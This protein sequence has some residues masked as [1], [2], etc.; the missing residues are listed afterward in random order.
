MLRLAAQ[1]LQLATLGT[2][3]SAFALSR[4]LPTSLFN[5]ST[6]AGTEAEQKPTARLWVGNLPFKATQE[7]IQSFFNP[8]GA[9]SVFILR[10]K[11]T[12]KNR[13]MAFV[14]VDPEKM[15]AVSLLGKTAR[16]ATDVA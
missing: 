13:G 11:E 1:K 12:R 16:N 6:E 5:F 15:D 8:Y 2:P 14:N 4:T 9:S 7:Q 10:D 3:G